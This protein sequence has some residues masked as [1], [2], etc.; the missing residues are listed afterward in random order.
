MPKP[1]FAP[2]YSFLILFP[3]AAGPGTADNAKL[4]LKGGIRGGCYES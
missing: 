2:V 1:V 3:D 4:L